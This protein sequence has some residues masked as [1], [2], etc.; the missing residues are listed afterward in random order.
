MCGEVSNRDES[1]SLLSLEFWTYSVGGGKPPSDSKSPRLLDVWEGLGSV[2]V[3][4]SQNLGISETSN[5]G[6]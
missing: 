3:P 1:W 6:S 4:E 5:L 2:T